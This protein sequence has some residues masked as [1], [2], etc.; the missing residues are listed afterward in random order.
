MRSAFCPVPAVV[1]GVCLAATAGAQT[2]G[3]PLSGGVEY[4]Y[5]DGAAFNAIGPPS[6]FDPDMLWGNYFLTQP[7]GE[8]ITRLTVE[9]GDDF[10]SVANPI[11]FWLLDDP[12]GDLDPRNATSVAS[13]TVTGGVPLETLVSVDIPPTAVG[14]GFFV[15]ASVPLAGGED[16]PANLDDDALSGRSWVFYAPRIADVIDSLR[17]AP[18]G[19][20]IDGAFPGAF[21]VRAQGE[22]R[23]VATDAGTELPS[24]TL[25]L[26]GAN[27]TR[28]P[29]ALQLALAA[30][31]AVLVDV[32]DTV[33]R[34]VAV[35][36]D[37]ALGAGTHALAWNARG[38][39]PGV[40]VARLITGGRTA[41]VRLAVAP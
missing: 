7:G 28:G 25:T 37:G 34:R 3:T 17:T 2:P 14:A 22:P 4:A 32:A 24:P 19:V 23:P 38:I 13:V 41:A 9:F 10:P 21:V 12:D 33:G 30:P 18:Y 11:T 26:T 29:V 39:A 1:L 36:A 16:R 8:T 40:Y 15:G 20:R 6:T 27:P 5:D 35:L 31:A